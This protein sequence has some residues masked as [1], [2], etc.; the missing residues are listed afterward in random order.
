MAAPRPK[1][2]YYLDE[3]EHRALKVFAAAEGGLTQAEWTEKI[4][5]EAISVRVRETSLL[6]NELQRA[7]I[8]RNSPESAGIAGKGQK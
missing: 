7:G 6:A 8:I 4:I 2:T 1:I 5:K 3:A